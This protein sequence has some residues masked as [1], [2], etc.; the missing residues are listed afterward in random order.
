MWTRWQWLGPDV[1]SGS[2]EKY[3]GD[4][5]KVGWTGFMDELGGRDIRERGLRED[6]T[7]VA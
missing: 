3:S 7:V 1:G 2:D 4:N 5:L 6:P